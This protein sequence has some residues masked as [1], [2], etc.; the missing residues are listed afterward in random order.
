MQ[1][2]ITSMVNKLREIPLNIFGR[3]NVGEIVRI[4]PRRHGV[5]SE[6]RYE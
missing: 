3:S 4:R 5:N 1:L 2:E 6:N